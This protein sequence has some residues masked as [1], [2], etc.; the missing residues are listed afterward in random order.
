[1]SV[2]EH[3]PG[4]NFVK[5]AV[6]LSWPLIIAAKKWS[7]LPVLKWVIDPFFAYPWNEVPT[8]PIDQEVGEPHS[9]FVPRRVVERIVSEVKDIFI[10]DECICR[11]QMK[12]E[13]YPTSVGCMALGPAI[14][15][16]HPSHGQRAS[17]DQAIEHVR[18]AANAGLVANIAHVW[19][20]PVAF[21]LTRFNQLMFICFCDDCCCLY[22]THMHRRGANLDRAYQKLP[23]I[24]VCVDEEKCDGCGIC[25]ERCFVSA[26]ELH[27]GKA[28]PGEHCKACARCVDACPLGAVGLDIRDE[29]ALYEQL[30]GQSEALRDVWET[31]LGKGPR[32][33]RFG[34]LAGEEGRR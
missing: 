27:D 20:D 26:M 25:V 14:S 16:M 4:R 11:R 19:I 3:G 5:L 28:I 21:G 30:L 7:S 22:R 17:R 29:N 6:R 2:L 33:P 1:M 10:L 31:I 18:K 23:G 34:P 13:N 15:R 32:S 8:I 24:S 9:V 12:C